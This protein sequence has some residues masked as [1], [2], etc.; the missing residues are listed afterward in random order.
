MSG[1]ADS[2]ATPAYAVISRPIVLSE[3][4]SPCAI[5]T[6][7]ATGWVS[8]VTN[9]KHA[10]ASTNSWTVVGDGRRRRGRAVRVVESMRSR[11]Y[12]AS[13]EKT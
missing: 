1:I 10:A 13:E 7:S 5:G 3:T 6:S 8:V 11:I 12:S 4:C 9:T 2:A